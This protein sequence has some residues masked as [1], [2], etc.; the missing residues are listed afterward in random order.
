MEKRFPLFRLPC[1]ALQRTLMLYQPFK[2][3]QLAIVSR[4]SKHIVEKLAKKVPFALGIAVIRGNLRLIVGTPADVQKC[5]LSDSTSSQQSDDGI[6]FF[7]DNVPDEELEQVHTKQLAEIK[8]WISLVKNIFKAKECDAFL[9]FPYKELVRDTF[10]VLYNFNLKVAVSFY[11]TIDCSETFRDIL[12]ACSKSKSLEVATRHNSA[13]YKFDD[14]NGYAMDSLKI[15]FGDW[16][17]LENLLSL[18]NCIRVELSCTFF[19]ALEIMEF[20]KRW[21]EDSKMNYLS[22]PVATRLPFNFGN[23]KTYSNG[24]IVKGRYV[25]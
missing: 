17:T 7:N 4:R 18:R 1:L 14:S 20:L 19:N 6:L 2:L 8:M 25:E 23:L 12:I 16:V 10:D 24:Q 21:I 22:F 3:A 15:H 11:G 9:L 5:W 13:W